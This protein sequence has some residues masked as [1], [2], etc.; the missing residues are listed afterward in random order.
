MQKI[1]LFL[2]G[3]KLLD[4]DIFSKSDPYIRVYFQPNPQS[5]F[6]FI[7]RTETVDN[8]LNPNFTKSFVV[9]YIF[10]VHQELK[11]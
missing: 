1:E 3:R 10:E 11:F 5:K 9:D 8:N 4:Q 6:S 2:S 7:G